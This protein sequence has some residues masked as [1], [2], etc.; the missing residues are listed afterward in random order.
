AA[1]GGAAPRAPFVSD[2]SQARTAWWSAVVV[3]GVVL[4]GALD[5]VLS[6][7]EVPT[8]ETVVRLGSI[9]FGVVVLAALVGMRKAPNERFAL[10]AWLVGPLPFLLM[11][12]I[13]GH[14]W[15]AIGRSWEP[16]FREK[17]AM[18]F[19]A[20]L[21]PPNA[22]VAAAGLA[23][24][25]VT[26]VVETWPLGL[27]HSPYFWPLEPWRT[28]AYG[29]LF[30]AIAWRRGRDLAREGAILRREQDALVLERL[31]RVALAVHDMTNTPLQTLVA[32]AALI[33][34]DPSRS[35]QV[36]AGMRRAVDKLKALN[37]AFATYQQ[38]V[39][40]RPGDESFDPR[41]VISSAGEDTG[42]VKRV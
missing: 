31:A 9:A 28:F 39:H 36:A 21:A 35:P 1:G 37:E 4:A 6:D 2:A 33:E 41:A 24:C 25:I 22:R 23:L 38:N 18:A 16:L 42:P 20:A 10:A 17:L 7:R 26:V 5:R 12:P 3:N 15:D 13:L 8:E 14:R 11:L 27:R 30:L 40:W 34:T 19:L 32:S 29:L